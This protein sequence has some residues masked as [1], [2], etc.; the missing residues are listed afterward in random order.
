MAQN[1]W[2]NSLIICKAI[3]NNIDMDLEK[4]NSYNEKEILFLPFTEFIV[5]K[6]SSETKYGKKIFIIELTE[7]E[8]RNFVN[9]DNM[10]VENVNNLGTKNIFEKFYKS[11]EGKKVV[12]NFFN[13]FKFN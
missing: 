2:R 7:L 9:T 11:E 10:Q 4:L 5:E 8:N 3:R 6:I 12:E 1:E 13:E